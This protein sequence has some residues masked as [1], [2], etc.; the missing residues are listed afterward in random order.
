MDKKNNF[1]QKDWLEYLNNLNNR[2]IS[3]RSSSGITTWALFG[4]IGFIFFELIDRLPTILMDATNIFLSKLFITNFLN[5]FLVFGLFIGFFSIHENEKRKIPA[6]LEKI[7]YFSGV[8]VAKFIVISGFFSNIYIIFKLKYYGLCSLPY[9]VFATYEFINIIASFIS[10]ITSKRAKKKHKID[11]PYL[12]YGK[13]K[14]REN[15]ILFLFLLSLLL[16]SIYQILQNNYILNYLYVFKSVLYLVVLIGAIIF[17]I[18][19]YINLRTSDRELEELERKIILQN[20]SEDEIAKEF[21]DI[22]VGK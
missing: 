14:Y 5:F 21:S 11:L 10:I 16:F 17:Y 20:I 2:E 19:N 6:L 1:S 7:S 15:I 3:K 13:N 18:V 12:D 4:L 8:R 22:F 9:Y